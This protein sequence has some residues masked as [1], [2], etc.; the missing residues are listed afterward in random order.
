[1]LLQPIEELI[2]S[3]GYFS[4]HRCC[5]LAFAVIGKLDVL[6]MW[7]WRAQ[8]RVIYESRTSTWGVRNLFPRLH[9]FQMLP[10]QGRSQILYLTPFDGL[11]LGSA[12]G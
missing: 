3:R 8:A 4:N 7:V 5:H 12:P 1:M 9:L 10:R 2:Y 6:Q 11:V